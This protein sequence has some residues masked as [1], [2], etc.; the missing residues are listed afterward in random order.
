[1]RPRQ[2]PVR[3]QTS[4]LPVS[5]KGGRGPPTNGRHEARFLHGNNWDGTRGLRLHYRRSRSLNLGGHPDPAMR[6]HLKCGQ[7]KIGAAR[8]SPLYE[9]TRKVAFLHLGTPSPN[10]WDL[11]L[12]GQNVPIRFLRTTPGFGHLRGPPNCLKPIGRIHGV[13]LWPDFRCPLRRAS[14]SRERLRLVVCPSLRWDR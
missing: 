5:Q 9:V 3:R 1:M 6:G 13:H 14:R 8:P 10:P 2:F 11:T 4:P 7:R 12:S